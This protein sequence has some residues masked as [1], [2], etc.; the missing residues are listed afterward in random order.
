M[1]FR[2][3]PGGASLYCRLDSDP[4]DVAVEHLAVRASHLKLRRHFFAKDHWHGHAELDRVHSRLTWDGVYRFH[5]RVHTAN[6]Y[7]HS[8][9]RNFTRRPE[10]GAPKQDL[11]TRLRRMR[12]YLRVP[13]HR[14]DRRPDERN[15]SLVLARS[16]DRED[17]RRSTLHYHAQR[18]ADSVCSLYAHL[19]LSPADADGQTKCTSVGDAESTATY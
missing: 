11:V 9:G 12:C 2:G 18:F 4:D 16:G 5:L 1:N 7:G 15:D 19:D 3:K 14:Q 8:S 17:L 6:V 13:R 10:S